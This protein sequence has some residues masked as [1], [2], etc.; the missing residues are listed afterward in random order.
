MKKSLCLLLILS[1]LLSGCVTNQDSASTKAPTQGYLT[2]A[3]PETIDYHQTV[4]DLMGKLPE[5]KPYDGEI[6]IP[7][8]PNRKVY[9]T[10]ANQDCDFYPEHDHGFDFSV[11]TLEHYDVSQ[12]KAH[13]DMQTE[14]TVNVTEITDFAVGD[15][16]LDSY[17]IYSHFDFYQQEI[18]SR[19]NSCAYVLKEQY[20]DLLKEVRTAAYADGKIPDSLPEYQLLQKHIDGYQGLCDIYFEKV[21]AQKQAY[22]KIPKDELPSFYLYNVWI[23]F[24]GC[25]SQE[26]TVKNA[27]ITVGNEE[28]P[29]SFGQWRFHKEIPQEIM[30]SYAPP[31]L[32]GA[33]SLSG[34]IHKHGPYTDGYIPSA[35]TFNFD[36]K[37]PLSLLGIRQM[38]TEVDEFAI[39][40]I[41]V[42][43][44]EKKDDENVLIMDFLWDTRR[45]LNLDKGDIVEIRCGVQDQRLM[46]DEYCYTP[47]FFLDYEVRNREY[48]LGSTMNYMKRDEGLSMNGWMH[49]LMYFEGIDI[50][51]YYYYW[52]DSVDPRDY[53]SS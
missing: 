51:E 42:A 45:P 48:S 44:Y 50:G 41:S 23:E 27:V 3:I 11:Y 28:Y 14:Y 53:L 36:V 43:L 29:I 34:A 19:Y 20:D 37:E 21:N 52:N 31:G 8:E 2:E 7:Y 39:K 5:I 25:G 17:K 46:E 32:T 18:D 13:F 26:E 33:G 10:L 4:L 49:Y 47:V 16:G 22:E 12:I 35:V 24:T 30:D 9:I 40:D 6:M 38:Q 15:M 1:L